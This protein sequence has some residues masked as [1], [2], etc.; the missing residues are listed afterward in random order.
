MSTP[1]TSFGVNTCRSTPAA[2]SVFSSPQLLRRQPCAFGHAFELGPH[3]LR[4][5]AG[6][7]FR[8]REAPSPRRKDIL[9][10]EQLRE[11]DDAIRNQPRMLDRGRVVR[12]DA[13]HEDLSCRQFPLF[14]NPPLVLVAN[15]GGL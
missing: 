14:P 2:D 12:D 4:V 6:D 9:A 7:G 1:T 3:H 10:P 5:H 13:R 15:I 11:P 8:L